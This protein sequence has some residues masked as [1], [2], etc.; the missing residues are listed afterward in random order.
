MFIKKNNNSSIQTSVFGKNANL[1]ANLQAIEKDY[2]NKEYS[3]YR[4]K[5]DQI[6]YQT[7]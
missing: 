1:I 6:V 7:N 4:K 2:D 3:E 5:F